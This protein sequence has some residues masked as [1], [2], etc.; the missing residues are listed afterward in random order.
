VDVSKTAE[1]SFKRTYSWKIDK[2]AD[3]TELT[4]SEGQRFQVNYEVEVDVAGSLDS[5]WKVEGTITIDNNTPFAATITGV[6]DEISGIG[7][8]SVDCGD[9]VSFPYELASGDTL[10][11]TY[12]QSLSD[13][14]NRTNKAT[15]T[16][17]G[18]VGGGEGTATVDFSK[19]TIVKVDEKIDVSDTNVG[20]LGTV[21]VADAPKTF[22]YSLWFGK[23]ADA[24][25]YLVCGD[26]T[27]QNVASFVTNDTATKGT[28]DWTVNANVACGVGC[29]LT[30][31]YW[32]THSQH[33]PA[34]YDDTWDAKDGGDAEF[35][36]TGY[37][38]HEILWMEPKGGNAYLILAHQYIAAELNVLNGADVPSEVLDAWNQAGDLLVKY[39]ESMKIAKRSADRALAI[40]LYELLDDYNNGLIGPGHCSE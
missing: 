32:K 39:E 22:T 4:L 19:A 34:P 13:G 11:C 30:Q 21:S 7:S 31:G 14:T 36:D 1:T 16:T 35:L 15:V 12:S 27:H 8:V 37:S 25:V 5:D 40:E 23:H 20:S 3:Q 38:Y 28:D 10:K 18:A 26:N 29:T 6:S 9:D 24:D 17:S 2:R 33:G